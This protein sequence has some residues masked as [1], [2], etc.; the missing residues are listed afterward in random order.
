MT[1]PCRYEPGVQRTYDEMA[2]HYGTTILPA[3]PR[4]PRDK[5][6]VEVGVQIAQRW[7]L[8]RLRNETLFSL[9]A[10]N[11]RIAELLEDLNDRAMR[12]YGASRRELFERLDRPA[13]KPLP[14]ARFVYGEWKEAGSTSTTTST[15]STTTTR[16][17]SSSP[18]SAACASTSASRRR[19]SRSSTRGKRVASHARSYARGGYTTIPEHMPKAH[20]EH[21]EWT[22]SRIIRW[23]R[24]VGPKTRR[25]RRRDPRR[26]AAPRAG[27]PLLPRD[28]AARAALRRRAARGRVRP[29]AVR[30]RSLRRERATRS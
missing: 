26:A 1:T 6:K 11:A 20:R 24:T 19:R 28:P 10:L 29:R 14:A 23:A 2:Q 9:A 4:H 7:I 27:L 8:A 21:A 25:A 16:S 5:A 17:P 3:R 22:P 13:L 12:R 18:T 15:S 30:A